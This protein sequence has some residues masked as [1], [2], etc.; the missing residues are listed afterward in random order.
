MAVFDGML[1][2]ESNG[3]VKIRTHKT[4]AAI[5]Y[6]ESVCFYFDEDFYEFSWLTK[7][8]TMLCNYSYARLYVHM[9][10]SLSAQELEQILSKQKKIEKDWWKS[11]YHLS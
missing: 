1:L 5:I 8:L 6:Y 9:T 4:F 10:S 7:I 11:V 2:W 3:L